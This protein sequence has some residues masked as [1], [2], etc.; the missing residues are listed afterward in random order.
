MKKPDYPE[1]FDNKFAK[2]LLT[3]FGHTDFND[4][5]D[6][7]CWNDIIPRFIQYKDKFLEYLFSFK[8]IHDIC[9]PLFWLC[10]YKV[11]D[12]SLVEPVIEK[13]NNCFYAY[14][15]TRECNS[16]RKWA[17]KI[18][19]KCNDMHF[20]YLMVRD[21]N[22]DRKW[23]ENIIKKNNDS[24]YAYYMVRDCGS[25]LKWYK[26]IKNKEKLNEKT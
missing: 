14:R 15:M 26:S 6:N 12:N 23:A 11:I 13:N 5:D 3:Y 8:S 4:W 19:E 7:W 18:I 10:K 22:L 25:S 24:Y 21:C 17:E 2:E 20:A 1:D 16:D 9:Y